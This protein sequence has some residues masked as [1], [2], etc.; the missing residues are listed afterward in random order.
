MKCAGLLEVTHFWHLIVPGR[1]K[2][3]TRKEH[4]VGALATSEPSH[5]CFQFPEKG[6]GERDSLKVNE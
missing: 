5:F 4:T 3:Q 6:G 2:R 1:D